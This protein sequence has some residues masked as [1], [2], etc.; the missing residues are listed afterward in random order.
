MSTDHGFAV[1]RET[2]ERS[3][4]R[5]LLLFCFCPLVLLSSLG[6]K[7]SFSTTQKVFLESID[8]ETLPGK[9]THPQLRILR[10]GKVVAEYKPRFLGQ[11]RKVHTIEQFLAA[12]KTD[13]KLGT[14]RKLDSVDASLRCEIMTPDGWLGFDRNSKESGAVSVKLYRASDENTSAIRIYPPDVGERAGLRE[15]IF[16]NRGNPM[17]A[18][19]CGKMSLEIPADSVRVLFFLDLYERPWDLTINGDKVGEVKI[20]SYMPILVDV[21]GKHRYELSYLYYGNGPGA[22]ATETYKYENGFIHRLDGRF[23]TYLF[24]KA[25][26]SIEI[27]NG[28]LGLSGEGRWQLLDATMN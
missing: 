18:V 15:M 26:A 13:K 2:T 1:C 27:P 3:A 28:G 17:A 22:G 24:R 11:E 21:S 8:G 9:E 23:P 14:D 7:D 19:E 12:D 4:Y 20:D 25:P 16:D 10:D 5:T 6:C